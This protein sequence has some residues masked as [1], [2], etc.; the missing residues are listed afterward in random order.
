MQPAFIRFHDSLNYFLSRQQ[1]ERV[2]EHPFDWRGSIKDMLE[3]LG[4]PHPEMGL[5]VVN[6]RSVDFNYIVQPGDQIDVYDHFNAV[7]LPGRVPLRPPYPGRPRFVL[8]TH[9]GRQ[10]NYL[11]ML[12]FD[13][14]Y[15][16]DYPDDELAEVSH[17]ETRILLTRDTGLLKRS[18]VI[19][20][21]YTRET[22]PKRRIVEIIKRFNLRELAQPFKHCTRCN[23]LLHPAD[24]A[25]VIDSLP[26]RTTQYYDE[27][28]QCETCNQ[29]YWKGSHF[30]RLQS[31]LAK[32][33]DQST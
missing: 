18:L 25:D 10:A 21:Y 9:L 6:G 32:V 30:D 11:R 22:D 28:H 3:S 29:V 33:L 4:P 19:Y 31:F 2:I 7:E 23:G 5:L 15:R 13:T 24:K 17:N 26:G 14:L 1:R 20:G 16:N 8:D 12:G 27:F